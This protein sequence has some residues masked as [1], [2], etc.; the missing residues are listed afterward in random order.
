MNGN[1]NF[2]TTAEKISKHNP[3]D[4]DHYHYFS[5]DPKSGICGI[6]R[7]VSWSGSKAK[8]SVCFPQKQHRTAISEWV[9]S[10][11]K[12]ALVDNN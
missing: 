5:Y 2:R 4:A 10:A 12:T 1:S 6:A 9:H 8:G 11:A 3:L 7:T